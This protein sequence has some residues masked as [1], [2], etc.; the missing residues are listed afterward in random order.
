M[1]L[2]R[3][4]GDKFMNSFD[5][6]SPTS[7]H[8][9]KGKISVLSTKLK[10][11]K[12]KK[13]L[14][15]YGHGSIKKNGVYD[16]VM[17]ELKLSGV[18]FVEKNG[19]HPN[20][21]YDTV[22]EAAKICKEEQV[23][24]ILAVGGGS[25]VDCAKA[26]SLATFYEGDFW[27]DIIL[28]NKGHTL[29]QHIKIGVVLTLSATGSE[30]NGGA[31][32]SNMA[33]R[34]KL[35]LFS[36]LV[37][38]TFS[39]LD[40]QYTYSVPKSQISAG[41]CDAFSHCLEQLFSPEKNA[42]I[43]DGVLLGVMWGLKAIGRT[44]MDNPNDYDS[45]ANLMWGATM[46][47]NGITGVGKT[48][49]WATHQIEH[50]VSAFY[51]ITHG[52]GLAIIFPYWME[53]VL[54]ITNVDRFFL[55]GSLFGIIAPPASASDNEKIAVAK[56]IISAIRDFFVS[57]DMPTKLSDVGVQA[58]DIDGMVESVV[59]KSKYNKNFEFT[60]SLKKLSKLDVKKILELAM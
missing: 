45:H 38:P 44:A 37:N 10:E 15:L 35:A 6:Y 48:H 32:I 55:I 2:L 50:A 12:V 57:L 33:T 23:D 17:A 9:G 30:M 42:L 31:V 14:F 49:D 27:N 22:L 28:A 13:V 18:A 58:S 51:D 52:L 34:E 43:T 56:K 59:A 46:A 19:V 4:K 5:W 40:P 25:V 24:F 47:L 8:F 7:I 41:V 11:L 36:P 53:Y 3:K 16:D 54:D 39:I 1:K 60:G 26:I 29:P 21:R 20:P